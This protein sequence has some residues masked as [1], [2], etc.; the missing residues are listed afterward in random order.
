ML[1]GLMPHRQ[2][3][4]GNLG[5]MRVMRNYSFLRSDEKCQVNRFRLP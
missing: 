2:R 5:L 1:N 4:T 3:R